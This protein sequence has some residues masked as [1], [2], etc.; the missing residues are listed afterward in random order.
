MNN[1][2]APGNLGTVYDR[3]VEMFD[4]L[5]ASGRLDVRHKVCDEVAG[6]AIVFAHDKVH[7]TSAWKSGDDLRVLLR[8]ADGGSSWR[9][10]AEGTPGEETLPPGDLP[11]VVAEEKWPEGMVVYDHLNRPPWLSQTPLG[12]IFVSHDALW[13]FPD[14]REPERLAVGCFADPVMTADARWVVL[15]KADRGWAHPNHVVRFNLETRDEFRVDVPAADNFDPVAFVPARGKVLLFRSKDEEDWPDKE[16]AGPDAPE[17]RLLDPASGETEIVRGEFR[18]WF[19][20]T[21]RPLQ[22]SRTADV[23]WAAIPGEDA[24]AVGKYDTRRFVFE[25]LAVFP[26][27]RFGSLSTWVDEDEKAVYAAVMGDLLRLPLGK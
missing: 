12:R 2:D 15:A 22:E 14:G 24:T 7:A 19:H 8:R 3:L 17:F 13:R 4:R 27:V 16:S 18:P 23:V 11:A 6:S 1:P 9:R 20:Q 26:S 21:W 25:A 10:M 5:A